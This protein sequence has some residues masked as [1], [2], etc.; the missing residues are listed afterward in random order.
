MIGLAFIYIPVII[1]SVIYSFCEI[2]NLRGGG[3][4][5]VF[6]S[7]DNYAEALFD[8]TEF[9]KTLLTGIQQLI[10]DIPAIGFVG[11][12]LTPIGHA[13]DP[14]S[15]DGRTRGVPCDLLYPGYSVDG[16]D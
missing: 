1:N 16:T 14:E 2:K 10:I 13:C 3:F 9:T 12:K 8:D 4:E 15:E 7:W 6:V 11:L 5:L